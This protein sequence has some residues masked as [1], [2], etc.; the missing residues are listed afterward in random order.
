MYW[1]L[2]S[3][4]NQLTAKI[5]TRISAVVTCEAFLLYSVVGNIVVSSSPTIHAMQK[6]SEAVSITDPVRIVR[7][8]TLK[9][10]VAASFQVFAA[11]ATI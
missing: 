11:T 8:I 9:C 1:S 7:G 10:F 3:C 4:S 6:L 5:N 2:L